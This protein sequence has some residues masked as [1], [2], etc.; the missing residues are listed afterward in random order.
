MLTAD[1]LLVQLRGKAIKTLFFDPEDENNLDKAANVVRVFTEALETKATRREIMESFNDWLEASTQV[2]FDRGLIKLCFDRSEFKTAAQVVPA[3]LRERLFE[4]AFVARAGGDFKREAVVA[5]VAE[6]LE[7]SVEELD[8]CFYADLRE[9]ERI[10]D[11]RALTPLQLLNRYNLALAQAV[12]FRAGRLELTVKAE[13]PPE[14]RRLFR[15]L[16]F[17][18]LLTTVQG[19]MKKGFEITV[20]GP[21]SLFSLSQQYGM[22]MANFL[23]HLL[24]CPKWS[25]RAE[26][27][28]GTRKSKKIYQVD[29]TQGLQ[30]HLQSVGAWLPE[31]LE[32]FAKDWPKDSPWK[33]SQETDVLSLGGDVLVPDFVFRKKK[34]SRRKKAVNEVFLEVLG[35]WNKGSLK[36]R[37]E[38]LK[39]HGPENLIVAISKQ[40]CVDKAGAKK[41]D[42]T[43]LPMDVYTFRSTPLRRDLAALLKKWEEPKSKHVKR[44]KKKKA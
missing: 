15:A 3:E 40:L 35:Y 43:D 19:S 37:I 28:W 5:A 6:E 22:R 14:Y 4:A 2:K 9:N 24:L 18:R 12:L 38:L 36:K 20:D 8:E 13:G 7:L 29:S 26:V 33:L 21:M 16:K 42:L 32:Q 17:H 25:L 1:L 10:Q 34:K 31:D 11:F 39:E 41:V 30:S 44:R 23:P 27:L